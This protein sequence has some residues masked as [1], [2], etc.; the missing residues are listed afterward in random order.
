MENNNT[1]EPVVKQLTKELRITRIFCILSSLLTVCLLVG[2]FLVWNKLQ[3]VISVLQEAQPVMEQLSALD[4]E[5]MNRTLEQVN[6]TLESVD[7]QQVSESLAELDVDAIND[8]VEG[9]DTEELTKAIEN[10]NKVASMFEK[11][12]NKWNSIF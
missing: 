8:A 1:N 12:A 4:V 10:L 11:W 2:G 9:L 5:E 3:P 7:W 6:I